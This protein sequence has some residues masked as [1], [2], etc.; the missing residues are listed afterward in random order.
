MELNVNYDILDVEINFSIEIKS[1]KNKTKHTK[2]RT[3]DH[4]N[5][6]FLSSVYLLIFSL[7]P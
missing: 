1:W 7:A 4:R 6:C 3:E 2:V 5:S